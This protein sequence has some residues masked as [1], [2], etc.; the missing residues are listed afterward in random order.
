M[1][2]WEESDDVGFW[3]YQARESAALDEHI[4][5]SSGSDPGEEEWEFVEAMRE[6]YLGKD[7]KPKR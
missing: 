3:E 4:E 1:R 6:R 7:W 5:A 2:A